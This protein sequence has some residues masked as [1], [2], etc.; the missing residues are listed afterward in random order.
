MNRSEKTYALVM[1]SPLG[2]LGAR[3]RDGRVVSLEY[4][5]GRVPLQ[6]GQG[7]TAELA[8]E[9]ESWF[10]EPHTCFSVALDLGGT[11][12]QQQVWRALQDIPCGEVRTYGELA[13]QLGSGARA[14][15]NA[16][17]RN[18]VPIIVPCHRVVSAAGMGGYAGKTDGAELDRKRWLLA[19]EALAAT[20]LKIP[21]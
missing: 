17:R 5:P 12:F 9:L 10:R 16:C 11:A 19:H 8:R 13:R 4:L 1:N 15:G 2:R 6:R 18:P 21:A 20:G 3:L 14:V 7:V